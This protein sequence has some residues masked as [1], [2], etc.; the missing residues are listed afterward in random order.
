MID[1][2]PYI[3]PFIIAS[4]LVTDLKLA[5]PFELLACRPPSVLAAIQ[6]NMPGP[7]LDLQ[8]LQIPLQE[9]FLVVA[10]SG[11]E[12]TWQTARYAFVHLLFT[13]AGQQ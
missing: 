6:P 3:E 10:R 8:I 4:M 1:R 9:S 11:Q 7:P 5:R 2:H 13:A 12:Q